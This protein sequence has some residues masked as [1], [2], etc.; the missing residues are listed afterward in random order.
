MTFE[1]FMQAVDVQVMRR[2]GVSYL[3]LP[4][5]RYRDAYDDEM[6]PAECASEVIAEGF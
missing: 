2:V 4:D 1:E 3:D 6:S 5:F